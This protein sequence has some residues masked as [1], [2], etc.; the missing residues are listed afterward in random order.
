[1][2]LPPLKLL[3]ASRPMFL[4]FSNS[5]GGNLSSVEP[6]LFVILKVVSN[7]VLGLALPKLKATS[8]PPFFLLRMLNKSLLAPT[9]VLVIH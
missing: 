6:M 1:M 3:L 9:F 5:I 4:R 8:L 7:V 2:A